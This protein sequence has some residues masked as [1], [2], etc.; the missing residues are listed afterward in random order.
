MEFETVNEPKEIYGLNNLIYKEE[1]YK[2]ISCCFEVHNNLGKGFSEVVYK[3]A[4]MHEF[5]STGIIYA[6]EK[7]F[8]IKYKNVILPHYYFADFLIFDEII[9][10]V[11]AQTGDGV[12]EDH[13]KQVINYLA[14]SKCKLG[15]LVNFGGSNLQFKRIIL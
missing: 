5:N 3:D 15:L 12:M 6:R 11:K 13:F 14:A 8:E 4:L 2:I 10:E 9:L 7:K 1:V